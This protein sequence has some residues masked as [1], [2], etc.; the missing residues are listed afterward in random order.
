MV[1][2][3]IYF[4]AFVL[5]VLNLAALAVVVKHQRC[6]FYVTLF[7][8]IMISNF[9]YLTMVNAQILKTALVGNTLTY[10]GAAYIPYIMLLCFSELCH[11]PIK[12]WISF[13]MFGINSVIFFLVWLTLW[14]S[15]LYYVNPRLEKHAGVTVLVKDPGPLHWMHDFMVV[16]YTLAVITMLYKVYCRRRNLSFKNL[17]GMIAL[18]AFVVVVHLVDKLIADHFDAMSIMYVFG[19]FILLF[20]IYRVGK[21]DIFESI[22]GSVEGLK[23]HAYMNFDKNLNYL[24]CTP[25]LKEYFPDVTHIR[26]DQQ[27]DPHGD[28]V[29]AKSVAWLQSSIIT[30]NKDPLFIHV[31][32]RDLKCMWR[33]V[34]NGLFGR[35]S[36]YIVEIEDDTQQQRYMQ[37][38][39]SYNE[40]LEKEVEEKLQHIRAIQDQIILGLSD[41]V[42][43]RDNSTG[44]HVKRT[45]DS[46]R[47]FMEELAKESSEFYNAKK[48]CENIIKAAPMHDLG[49]ISVEDEIL[50]KPGR[51]ND[52]EYEQM[53]VHAQ[54]GAEMVAKA[55]NG[56]EDEDFLR[57]AQNMAQ[58]HH[59]RWN[60]Q[61]YPE[62]LSGENI[63]LEARI[64]AL[65]DVF[66]ALV[67]KR[68]YKEKISYDE[69]F[70]IIEGTL[71]THFDPDL[72]RIFLKCRAR[73]EEYYDKVEE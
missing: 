38:I 55:L 36:G 59:E 27:I 9:G 6:F 16:F 69:A 70:S 31:G 17:F 13:V 53:K 8:L 64:M 43:S 71:G 58:Y 18:E 15:E 61:G 46:V 2:N 72:G 5:S 39:S 23:K 73:L 24:G 40:V 50:K 65:A 30:G 66:D 35:H 20:L 22:A 51:F 1:V 4:T 44:G 33:T 42:E 32:D 49:K 57:V 11:L 10:F 47:I 12:K 14:G 67:S 19:E 63:P 45:S 7:M 48:Y 29:I 41:I 34:H 28:A 52:D 37:L 21:Y 3:I 68:C 60:G 54:R 25:L 56:V 62:G 26:V